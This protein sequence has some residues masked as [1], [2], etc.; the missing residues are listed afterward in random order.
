MFGCSNYSMHML[1][2]NIS[3]SS[4]ESNV[5]ALCGSSQL[6]ANPKLFYY[7]QGNDASSFSQALLV[8]LILKHIARV[9]LGYSQCHEASQTHLHATLCSPLSMENPFCQKI[10][11]FPIRSEFG[12]PFIYI[13]SCTNFLVRFQI[14]FRVGIHFGLD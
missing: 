8:P 1:I 13:W 9:Y 10:G 5:R 2:R 7:G 12:I 3:M 11:R 4:I 6:V 14:W